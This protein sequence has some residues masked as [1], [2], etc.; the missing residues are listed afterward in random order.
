VLTGRFP[1]LLACAAALGCG[2]KS[3]VALSARIQST[4]LAVEQVT[5]GTRLTG[6]FELYLEVGPEASGGS[7]VSL[8]SFAL[9]R[10][11]D[12]LSL[13][14]PLAAGPQGASF[15]LD[16]GKG[17][18]KIVPFALDTSG[19]LDAATRDALCAAPVQVVGAVRDTLSGGET[20]PLQ[21]APLTP[22]GC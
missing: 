2:S 22:D 20:T 15:P 18:K 7:T 5:L 8:E 3:S 10:Q 19:L 9:V 21:G 17:Q 16:V 14:A 12:Q 11:S 1:L 13:V 4:E 6:S